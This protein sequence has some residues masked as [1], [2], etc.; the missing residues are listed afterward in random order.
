MTKKY[1]LNYWEKKLRDDAAPLLSLKYFKPNY[2]SLTKPHP[3]YVTAGSSP[4]EVT[5]ACVQGLFLSGRYR[6]ELLCS[7][8]SSNNG[9]F[10]LCPSCEG[11]E[12]EEDVEHILLHC[13]SLGQVRERLVAFTI[14]SSK[15]QPHLSSTLLT[16]ARPDN[17]LFLQFLLDCSVIQQV[18]CLVQEQGTGVLEHFFKVSRTWCYSLHRERL[19]ILG[20][21]SDY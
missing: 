18:I 9:G 12:V 20:R 15:S 2:M 5:K 14:S 16:L 17:E 1:I 13:G 11:Q 4:Y 21:W 19:K 6:T 10:C 8:W 3:L 7:N